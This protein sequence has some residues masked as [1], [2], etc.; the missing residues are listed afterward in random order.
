MQYLQENTM[1]KTSILTAAAYA[2]CAAATAQA[3]VEIDEPWVR[4]T[5]AQQTATGAFMRLTSRSDSALVQA[6]SPAARHVEI[7]EMAMENDVMKMRQID[8]ISLPAG[9]VV[10]LKPGSYHIML[11]ELSKQIKEG[12]HIPLTLTFQRADGKRETMRV[13]APARPLAGEAKAG[14]GARHGHAH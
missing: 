13:D 14:R 6:E 11:I 5:V 2:L 8:R 9:K 7:H 1:L 10:E 3:Q 12:D 4:A